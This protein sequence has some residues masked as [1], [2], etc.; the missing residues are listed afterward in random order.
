MT[1]A[2]GS[3]KGVGTREHSLG[4]R[5]AAC[6]AATPLAPAIGMGGVGMS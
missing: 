5:L 1:M 6:L 4:S 3:G 2:I